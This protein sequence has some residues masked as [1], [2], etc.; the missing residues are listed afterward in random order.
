MRKIFYIS[1]AFVAVLLM[2]CKDASKNA[3]VA[4]EEDKEAKA[5]LQGIWIN[6]DDDAVTMKVKGDSIIYADSTLAAVCFAVIND[7]LVLRGYNE[8]RYA[9]VKQ[10]DHIF[11]FSNHNGDL[12]K[13][14]KS[15]NPDDNYAFEHR[16]VAS[17]NQNQLI[18]RDSI[19]SGA[20]KKY[21]VYTTVNPSRYKVVRTG[22]NQDGLQVETIYY[23]NI[24]NICIYDGGRRVFSRDMHK[25]DFAK[26]VPQQFLA[27]SILSDI[28]VDKV[29][30]KGVELL[31]YICVPDSSTSYIVRIV[32]SHAGS[33]T[34]KG[35]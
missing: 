3:I 5:M 19:V 30:D 26:H 14:V 1:F 27:Q 10:T 8:T 23:D 13:L 6:A 22:Y 21:R 32:V 16:P 20:D 12:V 2:S 33:M 17:L 31:A 24:I 25:Q 11:Q 7:S 18:K 29:S 35:E 4:E 9:I 28:I 34:M 15:D